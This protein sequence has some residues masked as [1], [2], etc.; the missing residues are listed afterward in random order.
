MKIKCIVPI[1]IALG[2]GLYFFEPL[3]G[4]GKTYLCKLLGM[5]IGKGSNYAMVTYDN[6]VRVSGNLESATLI[7]FDRF[8]LYFEE[9]NMNS[10]LDLAKHAIVLVD[11]KYEELEGYSGS[12][13]YI[14]YDG[15]CIEVHG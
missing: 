4:T 2:N 9:Y 10:L 5:L 14:E 7:V 8:N 15:D 6:G 3:G 1:N 12:T 11:M 13:A